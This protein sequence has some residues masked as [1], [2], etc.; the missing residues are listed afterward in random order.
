MLLSQ[1]HIGSQKV[2]G[3]ALP[4]CDMTLMTYDCDDIDDDLLWC[5]EAEITDIIRGRGRPRDNEDWS[6]DEADHGIPSG[7]ED[8]HAYHSIHAPPSEEIENHSLLPLSLS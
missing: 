7:S 1:S 6:S 2:C 4:F 3:P 5:T 8:D